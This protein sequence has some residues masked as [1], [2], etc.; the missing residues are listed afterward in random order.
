MTKIFVYA[1]TAC[2]CAYVQCLCAYGQSGPLG[3]AIKTT[4]VELTAPVAF[5]EYTKIGRAHV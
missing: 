3:R 1:A 5:S 2:L 4:Q